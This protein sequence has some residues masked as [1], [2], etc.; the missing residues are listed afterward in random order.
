MGRFIDL[1]NKRFGR[2]VVIERSDNYISPSNRVFVQWLCECDCGNQVVAQG[3]NLRS[4]VSNSCGCHQ[5]EMTSE[6]SLID[7][8]GKRFG[9]LLVIERADNYIK[10]GKIKTKWLCRCDCGKEKP[11]LGSS[12][13]NGETISCGCFR[14]EKL[15]EIKSIDIMG[16]TF[17]KL[18][19]IKRVE[20]YIN[21]KSKDKPIRY[22]CKCECGN[23][24]VT[25]ASDL[26]NRHTVSCG[27]LRESIIASELKKHFTKRYN[28][29]KEY[30]ILKNPRT[31]HWL[32]YDIYIPHGENQELN[33]YYI[34]VHW[35]Q[36]YEICYFHKMKAKKNNTTPEEEF[37][38]QKHLD[39]IKRSFAK[40]HGKYIEIDLRKIKTI[41]EAIEHI[42]KIISI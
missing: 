16:K 41:N 19:V 2:L 9:R 1:T 40:K 22:I 38:Y 39:K 35:D 7:L 13:K 5:K 24:C 33:G 23:I 36:H 21:P 15:S 10:S 17:G 11:I 28:A 26:R 27:C 6:A 42:E 14:K 18:T 3:N 30:S 31:N 8:R 29:K 25:R 4:G 37:E 34:E 20:N 32:K 12:L